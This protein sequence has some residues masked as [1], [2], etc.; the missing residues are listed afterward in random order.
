MRQLTLQFNREQLYP[1]SFKTKIEFLSYIYI[2]GKKS[3]THTQDISLKKWI[4]KYFTPV[5]KFDFLKYSIYSNMLGLKKKVCI[6]WSVCH[7]ICLH[8]LDPSNRF[9]QRALPLALP[10]NRSSTPPRSKLCIFSTVVRGRCQC[11]HLYHMASFSHLLSF[12]Q[13]FQEILQLLYFML[14]LDC[15]VHIHAPF[16]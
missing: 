14:Y 15:I 2:L 8:G 6:Q 5:L 16:N 12:N 10:L 11:C 3:F 13:F 9:L 1:D 4:R 7:S